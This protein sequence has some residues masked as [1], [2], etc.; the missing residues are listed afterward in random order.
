HTEAPYSARA[1][2][3]GIQITARLT[4]ISRG[5]IAVSSSLKGNISVSSIAKG[6]TTLF[7]NMRRIV[8][9]DSVL[10]EQAASLR[11]LAPG[12]SIEFVIKKLSFYGTDET[13]EYVA[14]YAPSGPGR[15]DI[16]LQYYYSGPDKGDKSVFHGLAVS[17]AVHLTLR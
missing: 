1:F 2:D 15:Y 12:A 7:P 4:N 14:D 17:N 16:R 10:G 13:S 6:A 11:R 5:E 9:A 3:N 8:H